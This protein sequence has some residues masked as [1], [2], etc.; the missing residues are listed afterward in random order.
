MN[1]LVAISL[2]ILLLI[3]S[4]FILV[5][6]FGLIKLSDFFKRLHTPTKASTLGVGCILVVSVGYHALTG[7]DPQP[8]ELLVTAF[9]FVTAP[10]SAHLMAKAALS[11]KMAQRPPLPEE[12]QQQGKIIATADE[13]GVETSGE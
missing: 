7:E 8:R 10:I 11:L 5:G 6:A 3:G 9:L 13:S 4:F 12:T 1:Q 2:A